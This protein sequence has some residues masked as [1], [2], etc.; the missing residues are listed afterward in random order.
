VALVRV[1]RDGHRA[2]PG[3]AVAV[4]MVEF[5]VARSPVTIGCRPPPRGSAHRTRSPVR[6]PCRK[7][8]GGPGA[9]R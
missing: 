9:V 2:Q 7:V 6:D 4:T 8:C 5:M 3:G 1:G